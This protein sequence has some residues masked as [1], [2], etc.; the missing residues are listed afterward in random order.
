MTGHADVAAVRVFAVFVAFR[1]CER[2]L[3]S[4]RADWRAELI[5]LG[6]GKGGC[7]I[8]APKG[9]GHVTCRLTRRLAGALWTRAMLEMGTCSR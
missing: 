4:A 7:A 5:V 2:L 9:E 8:A 3:E 1:Q 6:G